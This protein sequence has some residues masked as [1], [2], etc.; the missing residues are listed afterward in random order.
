MKIRC[1]ALTVVAA[2]VTALA[3]PNEVFPYGNPFFAGISIAPFI[4]AIFESP[5]RRFAGG[6]G[7]LFALISSLITYFWLLFFQ[8]F[9]AWTLGGVTLGHILYFYIFSQFLFTP[10]RKAY[11]ERPFIIGATWTVYEYLKS[12]GYLGFPWGLLPHTVGGVLPLIQ[13]AD[14]TGIWGISFLLA[15]VNA[16]VAESLL[17]WK[18]SPSRFEHC[19]ACIRGEKFR[20]HATAGALRRTEIRKGWLFICTLLLFSLGYGTVTLKR[21]SQGKADRTLKV[22]LVQQNADS[23]IPGLEVSSIKTG[24]DITRACLSE[25]GESIDLVVWSENSFRA[26][27]TEGSPLYRTQPEGDT[28]TSF[29]EEI[30][31]PLLVGNP[32]VIDWE[33]GDALNAAVLISPE[34]KVIQYYGKQH[35][36]PFA[37]SIPFWDIPAVRSFFENFVGLE[38]AGWTAGRENTVFS[39]PLKNGGTVR[40]GVPICFEDVFPGLCRNFFNSGAELLINITNDS[41]SKTIAGETQHFVAARYRAIENKRYLLRSTNAG[42][43]AVIDPAGR[44]EGSLPLYTAGYLFAEIPLESGAGRTAYAIL[45]DYLPF[46]FIVLL[47]R[48]LV[49][50]TGDTAKRPQR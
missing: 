48:R 47:L 5:S 12:V 15:S 21:S 20:T 16:L 44:I 13:I 17:S 34:G 31:T 7:A 36:V 6:M 50:Q 3:L 41:W 39:V 14:M 26:P 43:T 27:Y 45:G 25:Q 30:E 32:V 28:F 49:T 2:V 38:S 29:M 23:W 11:P 35:L 33:K 10:T 37:E 9:S 24:Q 8:E 46:L 19:T 1:C 22:A 42:V 4:I 40:F 18:A